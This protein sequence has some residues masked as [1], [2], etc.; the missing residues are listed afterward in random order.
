MIKNRV[1]IT[2]MGVVAPNGN[3]LDEFWNALTSGISGIKTITSFDTT[4]LH[5]KIGGEVKNINFE[6]YINPKDLRRMDRFTWLVLAASAMAVKDAGID[7]SLMDTHR[8]GVI[9]GS[10]IGGL[11]TIEKQNRVLV[12]KGPKRISPFMIPMQIINMATGYV[13]IQYG[14][15]GPSSSVVTAC[16]SGTN[17]IGDAYKI[18]QRGDAD[19]MVVGG[20]EAALTP[21]GIA[22]FTNLKALSTR[23]DEPE[24]ASRPFDAQRDGFVMGEGSGMVILESLQTAQKRGAKIYAEVVG[25]GMTSDAFH[26]TQPRPDGEGAAAAMLMAVKDAGLQPEDVDY[27]NAHG[28]STSLND[29][30]ETLAIK[31]V[32]GEHARK[33]AISSTKSMTGHLL[34]AAGGVECIACAMTIKTGVIHPTINYEFPDPECDLDYVPNQARKQEVRTTLSNSFGFGGHNATLLLKKFAE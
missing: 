30:C 20:T 24:K 29:K 15:R 21:L 5:V 16:A 3:G 6:D 25:Y 1:V 33:L 10:G 17:A 19:V 32:F 31:K 28:T 27:I 22:G 11:D 7:F 9:V 13:S 8:C 18:I 2:G 14:L 26:I 34:G 23:N 12:E 4:E